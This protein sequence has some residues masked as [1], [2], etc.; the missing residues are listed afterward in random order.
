MSHDPHAHPESDAGR[1]VKTV[2]FLGGL[3]LERGVPTEELHDYI[4]ELDNLVWV[5]VQNP[6]DAE[7]AM[8]ED[9][10]GFHPLALEDVAQGHRRPKVNEYKNYLL[11]VT[12]AV[13][14][15]GDV[16][17]LRTAEV[18]LFIGRNYLVVVHRGPVPALEEALARWMRGSAMLREGV[19][20]LLYTV[21]DAIIDSFVPV[22]QEIEV[23]IEETELAVF[24]QGGEEGVRSLLRLKRTL[25]ALRRVLYP[26][27]E[28][29]QLLLR[30]D[31]SLFTGNTQVFLRDVYDHV[32]RILDVLDTEREMASGALDASMTISSTRL[33]KTMKTLAVLTVAVAFVTSVFGAYGMNFDEIPLAKEPWGFWAVGGGTM[34]LLGVLLLVGWR[35]RWL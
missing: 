22:I 29:F 5:D 35:Q 32:L 24:T 11:L 21:L 18:N 14:S 19:G 34:A 2:A 25:V 20:F 28:I 4:R 7:L 31:H 26:L 27:R 30:R 33:N 10:F 6:G 23:E 15:A 13:V 1:H 12:H 9:V 3:S 17:E 8:L 16:R